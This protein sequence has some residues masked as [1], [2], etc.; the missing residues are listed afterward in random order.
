MKDIRSSERLLAETAFYLHRKSMN[1]SESR[2]RLIE[3]FRQ[4]D[5]LLAG[6]KVLIVDDDS[7]YHGI[8]LAAGGST[9]QSD[10][11]RKR[12]KCIDAVVIIQT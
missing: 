3:S 12:Q 1:M 11:R 10:R 9:D 4:R 8:A 2:R 7:Q 6:K 5:P